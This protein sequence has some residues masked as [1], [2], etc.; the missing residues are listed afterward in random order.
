MAGRRRLEPDRPSASA[1]QGIPRYARL[2]LDL[3]DTIPP[4]TVRCYGEIAEELGEG[5]PRQVAQV[6]SAYGQEVPWHRVLRA[7]GTCAPE[8]AMRQRP[9]LEAEGVAFVPNT[10]RVAPPHRP[11]RPA[12]RVASVTAPARSSRPRA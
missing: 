5:G 12:R 3:V 9:L 8:V 1:F 11:L 4:G 10:F 7:D 6:M 2:V